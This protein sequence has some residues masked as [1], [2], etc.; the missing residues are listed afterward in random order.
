M[1]IEFHKESNTKT[2][3]KT[4]SNI[5]ETPSHC[6]RPNVIASEATATIVV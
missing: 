6:P 3:N 2:T 5:Q 4:L 1:R